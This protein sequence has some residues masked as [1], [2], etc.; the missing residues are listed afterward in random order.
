MKKKEKKDKK[1]IKKQQQQQKE[2]KKTKKTKRTKTIYSFEFYYIKKKKKF[3]LDPNP[4]ILFNQKEKES[5]KK[6]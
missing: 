5:K 3:H 4:I 6:N 2:K 1:R